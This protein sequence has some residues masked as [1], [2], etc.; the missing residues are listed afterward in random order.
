M[1]YGRFIGEVRDSCRRNRLDVIQ[2]VHALAKEGRRYFGMMEIGRAEHP[3][4]N[5]HSWVLGIR[6]SHDKMFAIG[7]VGGGAVFVCD[8]LCF[9]GEIKMRAIHTGDL[10][11]RLPDGVDECISHALPLF[12]KNEERIK[13]YKEIRV[14]KIEAHDLIIRAVDE[15]AIS[16]A[17]IP[18]VLRGWRE[19]EHAEFKGRTAW[20]LFNCFTHAQKGR[21]IMS[22]PRRGIAL[23]RVFDEFCGVN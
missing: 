17:Q 10:A 11:S 16:N 15:G 9:S 6:S 20:S 8:N 1:P 18:T 7:V 2:E 21:G 19:P 4:D 23:H 22:L 13:R 14:M 3:I 12:V 5:G